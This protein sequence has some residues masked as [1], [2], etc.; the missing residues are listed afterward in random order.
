MHMELKLKINGVHV[1]LIQL[2][3]RVLEFWTWFTLLQLLYSIYF[4]CN[5]MLVAE[6]YQMCVTSY[7][8]STAVHFS[9][10]QNV[11]VFW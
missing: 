1:K 9:N 7:S 10:W 2:I 11:T 5:Y 3:I 8:Y 4:T 6:L